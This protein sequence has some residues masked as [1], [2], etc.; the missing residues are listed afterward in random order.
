MLHYSSIPNIFFQEIT[1]STYPVFLT[2]SIDLKKK[3]KSYSLMDF[4]VNVLHASLQKQ[5]K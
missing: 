4:L 1:S 2:L 5:E 3:N